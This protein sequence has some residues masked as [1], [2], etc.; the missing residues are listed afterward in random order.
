MI[1]DRQTDKHRHHL[2]PSA[3]FVGRGLNNTEQLYV[4]FYLMAKYVFAIVAATVATCVHRI[5]TITPSRNEGNVQT[6]ISVNGMHLYCSF[7]VFS[8]ILNA[9]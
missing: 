9:I 2:K 8:T 7:K 4:Y 3:H 6:L 1:G 5:N